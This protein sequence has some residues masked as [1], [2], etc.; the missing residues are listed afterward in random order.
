MTVSEL[1]Y[2][3]MKNV[4]RFGFRDKL[5]IFPRIDNTDF[6]SSYTAGYLMATNHKPCALISPPYAVTP[7]GT[8][9][10]LYGGD[11]FERGG[12]A[13]TG[14]TWTLVS[15][16]ATVAGG[17]VNCTVTPTGGVGDV[18]I[19]KLTVTATNSNT[20]Y[21]YA[22]I[23]T[24][25]W[26]P[27]AVEHY[28]LTGSFDAKG[29]SGELVIAD[30]YADFDELDQGKL[31]L[32]HITPNW[33]GVPLAIGG[34]KRAENIALLRVADWQYEKSTQ[35]TVISLESPARELELVENY[36][37]LGDYDG[38]TGL[39]RYLDDS[40]DA[41]GEYRYRTDFALT[42]A[43]WDAVASNLSSVATHYNCTIWDDSNTIPRVTVH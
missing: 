4:S 38:D 25:E 27:G 17:G 31:I 15:G 32:F 3:T 41:T 37:T 5:A 24:G 13:A 22:Y 8:G 40:S 30:R 21:R 9:V 39:I 26:Q 6:I 11:S 19:V 12:T 16:S 1:E 20:N 33:D 23:Y 7:A 18:V 35:R 34:Y 2:N 14:H 43:V 36:A 29:W 10:V 28:T 42:D